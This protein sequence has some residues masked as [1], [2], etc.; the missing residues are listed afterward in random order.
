MLSLLKKC[1]DVIATGT[2]GRIKLFDKAEYSELRA[3]LEDNE[4][5][6]LSDEGED[7]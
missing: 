5:S 3:L 6:P 4:E 1:N 2:N 7:C